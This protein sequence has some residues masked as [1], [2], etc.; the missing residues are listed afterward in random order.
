MS[1][2]AQAARD[3]MEKEHKKLTANGV[4]NLAGVRAWADVCAE[5]KAK[6]KKAHVGN[7]FGICVEKNAELP[8]GD[9]RR[10]FKGRYVYQGNRTGRLWSFVSVLGV[11]WRE[12]CNKSHGCFCFLW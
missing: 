2:E 1:N 7:V 11:T 10:R 9:E 8:K 4:W 5:A 3:S 12:D 6:G